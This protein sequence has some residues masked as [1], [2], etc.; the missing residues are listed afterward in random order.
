MKPREATQLQLTFID[1]LTMMARV[2]PV[3]FARTGAPSL[4]RERR[5]QAKVSEFGVGCAALEQ[6]LVMSRGVL[7][8]GR[9]GLLLL[10]CV[11][12]G[13]FGP[14]SEPGSERQRAR[15]PSST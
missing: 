7:G 15:R 14:R 11:R 9:C 3:V 1:K 5:R 10:G 6:R 13:S 12:S 2:R 4:E 8:G